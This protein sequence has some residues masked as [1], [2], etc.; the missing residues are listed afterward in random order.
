MSNPI[1]LTFERP[2]TLNYRNSNGDI[3]TAPVDT[4]A[5]EFDTD[6]TPLG[7]KWT[8]DSVAY[9]AS[10]DDYL[11]QTRGSV[12][13]DFNAPTTET[14]Y[15]ID[16]AVPVTAGPNS[17][18]ITYYPNG[19][20]ISLNGVVVDTVSGVYDFTS[21]DRIE[22]GNFDGLLGA[23]GFYFTRLATKELD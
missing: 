21:L 9:L 10:A 11:G 20:E 18:L 8:D 1:T 22:V 3:L 19:Y 14:L 13:V 17:L 7:M 4:P 6:G 23:D 2:S 5:Y 15:V 16:S 12:R